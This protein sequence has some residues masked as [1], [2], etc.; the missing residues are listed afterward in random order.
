MNS[1]TFGISY[2]YKLLCFNFLSEL[3]SRSYFHMILYGMTKSSKRFD[4]GIPNFLSQI[5]F[6]ISRFSLYFSQVGQFVILKMKISFKN[7]G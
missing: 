3:Q 4:Q 6:G 1:F 2:M 5:L 7:K